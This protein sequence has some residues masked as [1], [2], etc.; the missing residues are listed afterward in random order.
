MTKPLTDEQKLAASERMKQVWVERRAK[1]QGYQESPIIGVTPHS[2]KQQIEE[3]QIRVTVNGGEPEHTETEEPTGDPWRDLPLDQ[4]LVKL[5]KLEKELKYAR[6]IISVRDRL[7]PKQ[8]TCW[9]ALNRKD[10]E[11][12]P[13]MTSTYAKCAKSIPDG[14]WVFKD[15]CVI[16][17]DTGLVDPVVTCSDRCTMLYQ[18]YRM[19]EKQKQRGT[20]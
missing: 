16:N 12:L 13:G 19:R 20:K 3:E 7:L 11:E 8:W 2:T 9:T 5:T 14:K 15:D 10:Q 17:K 4:A 18:L 1:A 6:A